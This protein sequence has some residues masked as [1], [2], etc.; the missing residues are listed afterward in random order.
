LTRFLRKR[1]PRYKTYVDQQAKQSQTTQKSAAPLPARTRPTEEYIEQDW[2]KIDGRVLDE[3]LDWSAIQGENP[4]EW[5]CVACDKVFR[6]EAAWT[7]HE[8]SRKHVKAVESLK[9]DMQEEHNALELEEEE[10]ELA[11]NINKLSTTD[12]ALHDQESS[13]MPAAEQ[14]DHDH[15]KSSHQ[16]A[17]TEIDVLAA[18]HDQTEES[19]IRDQPGMDSVDSG[20]DDKAEQMSKR[21]K[22]RA[23]QANKAGQQQQVREPYCIDNQLTNASDKHRC[24][25]CASTFSSRTQLFTHIREL[26]HAAA[27]AEDGPT[28]QGKKR[29]GKGGR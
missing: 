3:E 23:R 15:H 20:A 10:E 1:D 22:R 5:E 28:V 14:D 17:T 6:S 24:N 19:N 21:E 12:E 16:E 7:N 25:V 8:R 9:Q 18:E 11:E 4:E 29:R 2:Q 27:T 26:G 13:T